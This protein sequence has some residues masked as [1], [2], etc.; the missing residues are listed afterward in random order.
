MILNALKKEVIK[1]L[2]LPSSRQLTMIVNNVVHFS[3]RIMAQ[4]M[5]IRM[6]H[7]RFAPEYPFF[8][9]INRLSVDWMETSFQSKSIMLRVHVVS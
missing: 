3:L 5:S 6:A 8:C 1:M 7:G 4:M 9:L 2:L